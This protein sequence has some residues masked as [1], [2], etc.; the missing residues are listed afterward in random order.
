M[1]SAKNILLKILK[2]LL[3]FGLAGLLVFLA[4]RKVDWKT[5]YDGL[6]QTRWVWVV[7]FCI[8]SVLALF[9]RTLRWKALL[10]PFDKD[11]SFIKVW[12]AVNVGNV[13]SVAIPTSGELL[14]CG[15]VTTKK[16]QFDKALGTM[17]A[18]RVWDAGASIILLLLALTLQW[19]K[20]GDFFKDSII[21]PLASF[22][23]W[24]ILVLV[25][26][27][28]VVFI[29]LV[30]RFKDRSVFCGKVAGSISRLWDGFKAFGKSRNKLLFA[31]STVFIWSMYV[32]MSYFIVKAMPMLDGMT[33]ADALFLAAVGNIASIIPVP[34]G[35]GAYHYMVAATLGVY[36]YSWDIGILYATI[37]HEI[38][39]VVILIVGVIAYLHLLRDMERKSTM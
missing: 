17:F 1:A 5:F 30:F 20:L 12:D 16:L 25:L 32:L 33:F 39:A 22:G 11:I 18:E 27:A 26:L 3:L 31:L 29:I 9:G 24:W 21:K 10:N 4:F 38:H 2:Y 6:L 28:V 23:F 15:Y 14:R 36:G 37:N 19:E 8:V 13:A 34:G 7:L 35:I